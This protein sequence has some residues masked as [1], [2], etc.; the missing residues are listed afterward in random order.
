MSELEL[1][2]D[3][4]ATAFDMAEIDFKILEN[5]Q[6]TDQPEAETSP[7]L[8]PAV[9]RAGDLWELGAHRVYCGNAL[10]SDSFMKLMGDQKAAMV[11]SDPPYNVPIDGFVSGLGAVR[12]REFPMGCGEMDPQQFTEFLS[13][14]FALYARHS[15]DGALHFHCMDWRHCGE[16]TA[17]GKSVYTEL[18]ALCIWKKQ[19]GMGSL[20]VTHTN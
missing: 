3:L 8:G 10:E 4:E 15:V 11:F 16:M 12:H 7:P 13:R 5:S 14:S 2:F 18:K 1:D 6:P 9:T 17:A 19:P 20:F